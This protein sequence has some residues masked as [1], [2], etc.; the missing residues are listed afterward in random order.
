L[1]RPHFPRHAGQ[2]VLCGAGLVV[3]VSALVTGLAGA[4]PVEGD[5]TYAPPPWFNDGVAVIK[6][7][8]GACDSKHETSVPPGPP[9]VPPGERHEITTFECKHRIPVAVQE[10]FG[11][12]PAQPYEL[13]SANVIDVVGRP[14]TGATP[15]PEEE[16]YLCGIAA[17]PGSEAAPNLATWRCNRAQARS[18]HETIVDPAWK[19][20]QSKVFPDKSFSTLADCIAPRLLVS[21]SKQ[22]VA[23]ASS[24]QAIAAA[25]GSIKLKLVC[26]HRCSLRLS[27]T[28]RSSKTAVFAKAAKKLRR[29]KRSK[30]RLA[31]TRRGRRALG[32][33]SMKLSLR[34]H[35][36]AGGHKKSAKAKA[37]TSGGKLSV[38]RKVVYLAS[39]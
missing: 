34:I 16:S 3:A 15:T 14:T 2:R 26:S 39:G 13:C 5:Y 1:K 18:T 6:A 31:L 22:S 33:G 28:G 4:S 7:R 10:Q 30:V 21:S 27:L 19:A 20:E 17:E 12:N 38:S 9:Y 25:R 35:V 37:R 29:G 36:S 11:G 32:R 8:G 24:E 23:A